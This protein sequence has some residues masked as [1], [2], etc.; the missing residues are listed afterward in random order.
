[1]RSSLLVLGLAVL[2]LATGACDNKSHTDV[3][4][5]PDAPGVPALVASDSQIAVSWTAVTDATAYEVWYGTTNVSGAA[6]QSGGNVTGTS[7]TIVGLTNGTEYFVF[8]KAKNSAGT[9]D[10]GPSASATPVAA[11]V[12]PAA[13]G[14]PILAAGD[15]KI[16]VSWT[17][18]PGATAYEVWVGTTNASGS[19]TKFGSDLPGTSTTINS[20]TNGTQY[21][22]FL[23]AKNNVGT[24]DFGPSASATPVAAA[25]TPAAPAAPALTAGDTQIDVSWTAVTGATAYEVWY[26]TTSVSSAATKFGNDVTGTST[27]ITGLTNATPYFVFL[28]AKNNVGT[29]DFGPSASATPVAAF[30]PVVLLNKPTASGAYISQGGAD[31]AATAA[32]IGGASATEYT[33]LSLDTSGAVAFEVQFD[34]TPSPSDLSSNKFVLQYDL[35]IANTSAPFTYIQGSTWTAGYNPKYYNASGGNKNTLGSWQTV[36]IPLTSADA[37]YTSSSY[38]HNAVAKV[39]IKVV[40][41]ATGTTPAEVDFALKNV[42][43]YNVP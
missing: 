36:T 4:T 12:A 33:G 22:V 31:K 41:G 11:A 28:K 25:V 40:T 38:T 30:V 13:P 26:G 39:R 8:L 15:A 2:A 42:T 43:V 24:S 21:F 23:K 35:W 14:A 29:S 5:I 3:V 32:T 10:F 34:L 18:V 19:A 16:D 17:A 7:A 9:S 6:I 20:L 27:T 37:G 1:M